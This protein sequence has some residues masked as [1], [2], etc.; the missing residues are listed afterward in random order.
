MASSAM[1]RVGQALGG[2]GL[3]LGGSW[4]LVVCGAGLLT[5]GVSSLFTVGVLFSLGLLGVVLLVVGGCLITDAFNTPSRMN[6]IEDKTDG[7]VSNEMRESR[8]FVKPP[9][10][11][12]FAI[13]H[14]KPAKNNTMTP[15]QKNT[16][17]NL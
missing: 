11:P 5:L 1:R 13:P 7:S 3:C 16:S 2:T 17:P 4:L 6:R 15:T 9:T 8:Q 12:L 10:P 14:S